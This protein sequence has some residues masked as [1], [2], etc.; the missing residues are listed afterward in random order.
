MPARSDMEPESLTEM[1]SLGR[2]RETCATFAW[3]PEMRP[4]AWDQASLR[5]GTHQLGGIGRTQLN[6]GHCTGVSATHHPPKEP[7]LLGCPAGHPPWAPQDAAGGS[8]ASVWTT[9]SLKADAGQWRRSSGPHK[10][11]HLPWSQGVTA[12]QGQPPCRLECLGGRFNCQEL[13]S[14]KWPQRH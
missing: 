4:R 3:L 9:S 2:F 6:G 13:L 12:L 11:V 10:S 7:P 1:L 8:R 5:R 14:G